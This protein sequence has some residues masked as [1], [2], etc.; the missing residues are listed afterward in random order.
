MYDLILFM[1]A[2][3]VSITICPI[4]WGEMALMNFRSSKVFPVAT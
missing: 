3:Q 4:D 2:V 1:I